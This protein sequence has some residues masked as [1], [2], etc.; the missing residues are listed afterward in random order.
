MSNKKIENRK[1]EDMVHLHYAPF[2]RIFHLSQDF[3]E[4]L[5]KLEVTPLSLA[6][7]AMPKCCT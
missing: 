5:C 3:G 6:D 1:K 4:F 7:S 2:Q